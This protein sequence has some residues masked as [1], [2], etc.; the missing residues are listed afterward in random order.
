LV[1]ELEALARQHSHLRYHRCVLEGDADDVHQL[2]QLDRLV[3]ESAPSF[4]GR[5]VYLCGDPNLVQ[6]LKRKI[7]LKGAALRDIHADAFVG[8]A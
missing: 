3:L 1:R 8:S 7:F 6:T 5:R 2:G 4:A